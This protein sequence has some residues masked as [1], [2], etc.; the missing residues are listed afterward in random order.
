MAPGFA[1]ANQGYDVWVGN[2]RGNIYSNPD[3]NPRVRQFWNFSIDEMIAYDLPDAFTYIHNA[4]QKKIHYV[5][6]SQG[7]M[8]MFGA[9]SER[10]PAIRSVL[11]SFSALGPVAYIENMESN[12]MKQTCKPKFLSGLQALGIE[13]LFYTN[14]NVHSILSDL[15][16]VDNT[17]CKMSLTEI[18]EKN[19]T[20]NNVDRMKVIMGHF[21]GGS[22]VKNMEH[23]AQNYRSGKFCKYDYGAK[24][25]Q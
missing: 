1:L 23:F 16:I 17:L 24:K 3:L 15:C 2:I 14:Q 12:L 21:P 10:N 5:G 7:T 20:D 4:T 9:L 13:Q 25:N 22:S 11:A 6:H 19:N 18:S 8:I